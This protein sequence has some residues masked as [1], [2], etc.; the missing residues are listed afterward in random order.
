MV[1]S[2]RWIIE[3]S[4]SY[5]RQ[6]RSSLS[7]SLSEHSW[8]MIHWIWVGPNPRTSRT[9]FSCKS[10][11]NFSLCGRGIDAKLIHFCYFRFCSSFYRIPSDTICH[12][13]NALSRFHDRKMNR[14]KADSGDSIPHL[15]ALWMTICSRKN[16]SVLVSTRNTVVQVIRDRN[17]H[18]LR[19][20]A[21]EE[22]EIKRITAI[23]NWKRL[24]CPLWT[25]CQSVLCCQW[26]TIM[27]MDIISCCCRITVRPVWWWAPIFTVRIRAG[28]V[29]AT[30]ISI[31]TSFRES[32]ATVM[33]SVLA[34][35]L[36]VITTATM[37][38]ASSIAMLAGRHWSL[39]KDPQAAG[40]SQTKWF[41]LNSVQH[42]QSLLR[43]RWTTSRS[44]SVTMAAAQKRT[45]TTAPALISS[46]QAIARHLSIWPSTLLATSINIRAPAVE[47]ITGYRN[48]QSITHLTT[49]TFPTVTS[50]SFSINSSW[51][52]SNNNSSRSSLPVPV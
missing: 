36:V 28:T 24:V 6:V 29:T 40:V 38:T 44:Y 20:A 27:I 17:R 41:I 3:Q 12:W 42:L 31:S 10:D 19:P 13:T 45:V 2:N 47:Q 18:R 34:P 32:F 8:S 35:I 4:V 15:R 46:W 50:C 48:S 26:W 9:L 22:W 11:E 49:S 37:A 23:D 33:A 52:N 1:R 39:L 30:R 7:F 21:A 43:R 25:I 5:R 51:P 16:D 14:V